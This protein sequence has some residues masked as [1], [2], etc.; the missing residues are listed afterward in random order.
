MDVGQVY[1]SI[2]ANGLDD[3]LKK[4]QLLDKVLNKIDGKDFRQLSRESAKAM[5][6]IDRHEKDQ[7]AIAKTNAQTEQ[8]NAKTATEQSK[9][10]LNNEKRFAVIRASN[11]KHELNGVKKLTTAYKGA[12]DARVKADKEATDSTIKGIKATNSALKDQQQMTQKDELHKLKVAKAGLGLKSAELKLAKQTADISAKSTSNLQEMQQQMETNIVRFGSRMQTLGMTLQRITQPFMDVYRGVLMSAGYRLFNMVS[13]GL[14]SGFARY[15]TMKM[16]PK[17][18]AE[19]EK[20]TYSAE[21]SIKELNEAVLGLP[22]GLDEITDMAQRYTLSL[23]DMER[24]TKLAI[25]SNNAFIASMATD[26]QKYQGILQ[27]QDLMNG[28]KLQSREWMSL[29]ASMGK[30]VNEI[31]KVMGAETQE[32][33]R[34]FRQ[35][36]YA[37]KIDTE[38]FLD[39][40]IKVGTNGGAIDKLAQNMKDT[41]QALT[42]NI[43]NANSRLVANILDTLDEVFEAYTGKSF[44]KNMQEL[45]KVIDEIGESA[46]QWVRAHP[47]EIAKFFETLKSIDIKGIV[48]EF[49]SFARIFGEVYAGI[50]KTFGGA[51]VVRAALITNMLGK[52]LAT[53]GGLTKGLA[54]PLAWLGVRGG[55]AGVI[56]SLVSAISYTGK[57]SK[58]ITYT[59]KHGKALVA[60]SRATSDMALTW[61][62]VASKALNIGAIYVVAQAIKVMSEAMQNFSAVKFSPQMVANLGTATLLAG[63][64]VK[65]ITAMGTVIGAS[66][67]AM[68][69]T[70][71]GTGAFYGI[72][73]GIEALGNAIGRIGEGMS[74]GADA[75]DKVNKLQVPKADKVKEV[76]KALK[77]LAKAFEVEGGTGASA[78]GKA[79]TAWSKGLQ[80]DNITK[81]SNT[82]ESIQKLSKIKISDTAIENA[83][84]NFAEIQSFT[85]ELMT[86]FDTEEQAQMG[87]MTYSSKGGARSTNGQG[88]KKMLYS[89]WKNKVRD[90]A[91]TISSMSTA[92]TDL[93][94]LV[95][96][97][98]SLNKL[99]KSLGETVNGRQ[100]FSWETFKSQVSNL[101]DNI[102]SFAS[103]DE[104]SPFWKLQQAAN[105]LKGGQYTKLSELFTEIPKVMQ[106]MQNVY[107]KMKE[108][109]FFKG[110]RTAKTANF[111][112]RLRPVIDVIDYINTQMPDVSNLGGFKTLNNAL[113]KLKASMK[114]LENLSSY[115]TSGIS[116]DGIA[117]VAK[118]IKQAI[119]KIESIGEKIIEISITI[120]GTIEDNGFVAEL[121]SV[122]TRIIDALDTI[123]PGYK[124]KTKV[125][126]NGTVKNDVPKK[127]SKAERQIEAAVN[128]IPSTITKTVKVVIKGVASS[129]GV[130][131]LSAA[132]DALKRNS[133]H[134]GRIYR[135]NGGSTRRGTDTVDAKLTP[136]EWV[137]NRHASSML[138]DDILHKLNTLD[139]R[140]ALNALSLKAGQ[141]QNRTINN[142]STKNANVTVNN[143]HSDGV[144]YGRAS[145][146]VRSL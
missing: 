54:T 128:A 61:Q 118:K 22:T 19:Y 52:F 9:Q 66:K 111:E 79:I 67:S 96:G 62:G 127:V 29:G 137:I 81:I 115:D 43:K 142:N 7:A 100:E 138:G 39:A 60:A 71:I 10:R 116:V 70:A 57:H 122:S 94:T 104:N 106:G 89:E 5:H 136:G 27:L 20:K 113:T 2:E 101:A 12:V 34:K 50:F 84:K 6:D 72:S 92:F 133:Q 63:S 53:L 140:G 95:Q 33:I 11:D 102:Y 93:G 109:N 91:E 17:M 32:D 23:G 15:D 31:A 123:Q 65:F 103:N 55:I 64:L 105:K 78:L 107:N 135:A 69:G 144:G 98:K 97:I 74:A 51:N 47:E 49:A 80:A 42:D 8:I 4:A 114:Q 119:K 73:K 40:L 48:S 1:F 90:F 41:W 14:A 3:V 28:K 121:E 68:I 30:A 134:G 99:Y 129:A 35:E 59:A 75:L 130:Q 83:K 126:V 85:V 36:L 124:K 88:G 37:G 86:L 13:S 82:M 141:I 26:T 146:V 16:Y 143:Y 108:L 77:E 120:D 131:G 125:D 110:D 132:Y 44:L 46:R 18:M 25:A 21:K 87:V 58:A 139:I 38:E 117:E 45:P 112:A 56:K 76:G 24:G 145:R